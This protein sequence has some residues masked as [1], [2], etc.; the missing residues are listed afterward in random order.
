MQSEVHVGYYG[1]TRSKRTGSKTPKR[2]SW[3][4]RCFI[5][6]SKKAHRPFLSVALFIS[7]SSR[8]FLMLINSS[9]IVLVRWSQWVYLSIYID[10]TLYWFLLVMLQVNK[11][12]SLSVSY[13]QSEKN[14]DLFCFL[15]VKRLVLFRASPWEGFAIYHFITNIMVQ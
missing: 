10:V 5:Y 15:S 13:S 12:A 11:L 3:R 1:S 2:H 7:L 14:T 4:N 9:Q 6:L 8:C